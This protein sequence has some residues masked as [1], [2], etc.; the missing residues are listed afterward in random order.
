MHSWLL[1]PVPCH[2]CPL[3]KASLKPKH[4]VH[5][6]CQQSCIASNNITSVK[7]LQHWLHYH[8]T[9]QKT[10][11]CSVVHGLSGSLQSSEMIST[12]LLWSQGLWHFCMGSKNWGRT[13]H[14]WAMSLG[15]MP[16]N[17]GHHRQT[18]VVLQSTKFSQLISWSSWWLLLPAELYSGH[19]AAENST[20]RNQLKFCNNSAQSW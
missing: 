14:Q 15:D 4:Y 3:A 13:A 9:L 6:R 8:F 20:L 7:H 12:L 1:K 11:E 18:L 2:Q 10:W 5:W 17:K 16:A 19:W